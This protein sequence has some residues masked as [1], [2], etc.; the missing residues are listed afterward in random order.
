TPPTL[1]FCFLRGL[2]I[3]LVAAVVLAFAE[4]TTILSAPAAPTLGDAFA[5]FGLT[6]LALAGP[7]CLTGLGQGLVA[8]LALRAWHRWRRGRGHGPPA[9]PPRRWLRVVVVVLGAGAII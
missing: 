1:A 2:S 6:L 8:W 3:A 5:L 9:G 7:A 4:L